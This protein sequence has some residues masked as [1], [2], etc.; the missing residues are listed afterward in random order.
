VDAESAPYRTDLR[1][2]SVDAVCTNRDLPL[3][4]T[5]GSGRTDFSL[6]TAAPVEAVRC[7]AGPT[8]PKPSH[9]HGE[10]AWR[11]V[12][13]L[14]LNYLSLVEDDAGRGSAAL[15]EMLALYAGPQDAAVLKQIEGVRA[16]ASAPV[17]RRMRTPGPIT[18]GRGLEITVTFDD[19]AF[20]GSVVFVLGA[21]LE[22]FFARYVSINSFT[23]TVVRTLERGEI[24]RWPARTGRSVPA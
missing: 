9:A 19:D 21:V 6:Q 11:L 3:S 5:L 2:L 15:R 24:M 4:L 1:Q 7:V 17:I 22:E 18:F 23:E 12:S 13:H 16:V 20:R 14:A 8:S 10:V